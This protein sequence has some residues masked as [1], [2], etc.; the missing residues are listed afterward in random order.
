MVLQFHDGIIARATYIGAVPEL[1]AVT[2]GVKQSCVFA[3]TLFSLLFSAMLVDTYRDERPGICAVYRAGCHLL[4]QRWMHLQSRVSTTT[5]HELL[6]PDDCAL[7]ATTEGD[8]QR[9]MELSS[10]AC[11]DFGLITNTEKTVVM[12]RLQINP[13]NW[14][15]FARARDRPTCRRTATTGATIF[16]ANLITARKLPSSSSSSSSSSYIASTSADVAS[17]MPSNATYNSV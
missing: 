5:V 10:A 9:G 12:Q 2:N 1:F 4:N 3:S 16:K 17:V 7:N 13:A 8:M 6:F 11:K 15:D 14:E